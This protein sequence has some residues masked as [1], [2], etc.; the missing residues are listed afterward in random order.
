[1]MPL[2][3]ACRQDESLLQALANHMVTFSYPPNALLYARGSLCDEMLVLLS[4]T[5]SL[6]RVAGNE[7]A[8][9]VVS[10]G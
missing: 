6:I 5:V 8:G 7:S 9:L 2:G 4:G 3:M 10:S 1:M